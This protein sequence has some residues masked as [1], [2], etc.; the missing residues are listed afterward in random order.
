MGTK[1]F[2]SCVTASLAVLTMPAFSQ[3]DQGYRILKSYTLGGDGG[4]DY[5]NLDPATGHLFIT[6]GSHVMVI[7]PTSGKQLTD[8]AGL[9][10]IHGTA[11]VGDRAYVSEGDANR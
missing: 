11:F 1:F 3:G 9:Q 5:L 10:G 2:F 4:W 8:I 6:R 7:D